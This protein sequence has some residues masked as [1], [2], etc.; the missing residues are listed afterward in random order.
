MGS[1]FRVEA[2]MIS[3]GPLHEALVPEARDVAF[4]SFGHDVPG[5]L[6]ET[7]RA[8]DVF[9]DIGAKN[10]VATTLVGARAVGTTGRVIALEPDPVRFVRLLHNVSLNEAANTLCFPVAASDETI[11]ATL[12]CEVPQGPQ[13][14]TGRSIRVQ[15]TDTLC[16][17]LGCA[18]V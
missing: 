10:G 8:G 6:R 9:V 3:Y 4:T 11:H 5:I 2:S 17:R 1:Y 12:F 16:A 18:S 15:R 13:M 7:L 14:S